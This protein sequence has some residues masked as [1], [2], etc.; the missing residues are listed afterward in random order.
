MADFHVIHDCRSD[1]WPGQHDWQEGYVFAQSEVN[2]NDAEGQA[3]ALHSWS[4]WGGTCCSDISET[5]LAACTKAPDRGF[6][7]C[8]GRP[9]GGGELTQHLLQTSASWDSPN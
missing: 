9:I 4:G 2:V 6:A 8:R 1:K 5:E 7:A 3:Q